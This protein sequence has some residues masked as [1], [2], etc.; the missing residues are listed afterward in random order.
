MHIYEY[1][2]FQD[3][4]RARL[5]QMEYLRFIFD[6]KVKHYIWTIK[7]AVYNDWFEEICYQWLRILWLYPG[8]N[9]LNFV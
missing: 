2:F 4:L 6:L 7:I 9:L 3:N 1:L 5:T 8:D